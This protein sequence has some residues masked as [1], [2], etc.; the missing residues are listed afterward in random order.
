MS[1]CYLIGCRGVKAS[2]KA[3][4]RDGGVANSVVEVGLTR[5]LGVRP[6]RE[7][8]AYHRGRGLLRAVAAGA[9]VGLWPTSASAAAEH[10]GKAPSKRGHHD[11]ERFHG[12][13]NARTKR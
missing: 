8:V 2:R 11:P 12:R 13:A 6:G 4:S 5:N 3:A 1:V 10:G 9:A 7:L